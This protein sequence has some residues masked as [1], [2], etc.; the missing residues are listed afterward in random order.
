MTLVQWAAIAQ[1]A[2]AVFTFIGVLRYVDIEIP[3]FGMSVLRYF[4]LCF[5]VA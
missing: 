5:S 3:E 4:R 2:A 1:V